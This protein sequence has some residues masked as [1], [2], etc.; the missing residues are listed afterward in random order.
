LR[1]LI[2]VMQALVP[3]LEVTLTTWLLM[4]SATLVSRE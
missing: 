2:S 1:S 3:V 4:I